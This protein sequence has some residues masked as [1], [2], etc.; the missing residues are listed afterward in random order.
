MIICIQ[1]SRNSTI[2]LFNQCFI[3]SLKHNNHYCIRKFS[4]SKLNNNNN[5]NNNEPLKIAFCGSDLFSIYSFK[6]L[7]QYS[8]LHQDKISSIDLITRAPKATGR[9]RK[10]LRLV[11]ILEQLPI[12]QQQY[13]NNNKQILTH[14][15]ESLAEFLEIQKQRNF[16]LVI[17]VS[18]G[19]LIPA[20][21]LEALKY[22]GLNVH[23]SL[24]P[25][26][27]GASPLHFA[28]LN[29]DL[30]TGVTV[31]TL[32]PTKFDRGKILLQTPPLSIPKLL[33]LGE[34]EDQ[35]E[36]QSSSSSSS[37]EALQS[38]D[39]A[40]LSDLVYNENKEEQSSSSSSAILKNSN[41]LLSLTKS[42][43]KIGAQSLLK[44]ID[45]SSYLSPSSSSL[46]TTIENNN[47]KYQYSYASR[48]PS[49]AS[50]INFKTM[51]TK[52][53]LI[54]N[55]VLGPLYAFQKVNNNL[56][57]TN[58]KRNDDDKKNLKKSMHP[59]STTTTTTSSTDTNTSSTDNNN[60]IN[61]TNEDKDKEKNVIKKRI[62]LDHL[63]DFTEL[64][65][66]NYPELYNNS[67]L[68]NEN[69]KNVTTTTQ[70]SSSSL[71]H[72]CLINTKSK[73]HEENSRLVFKTKDG[74][75]AAKI[76]KSEGYPAC[77]A[78]QF[79]L[80]L[81]KRGLTDMTFCTI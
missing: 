2:S 79:G 15:P 42:L 67:F 12:L 74:F 57:K 80:S 64:F 47:K 6:A 7:L 49:T 54:H 58:S 62:Q 77:S 35:K 39:Y 4:I 44:V 43:G 81:K 8:Q 60:I 38:I 73:K 75:I 48:I 56:Q 78:F 71:G 31:Q 21:F 18:Y 25:K 27:S 11:E 24:L 37:L 45:D 69:D 41:P 20:K 26:Y 13:Y 22:G 70:Q 33:A 29:H 61:N 34:L 59:E 46:S 76:I 30:Y 10:N 52:S 51:D 14:T 28:L 66:K 32:H 36:I 1:N 63:Q 72:Y 3:K 23:P 55:K 68:Q 19:K 53:I 50:Q 17:A 9:G 65:P 16:N 40:D 5:N